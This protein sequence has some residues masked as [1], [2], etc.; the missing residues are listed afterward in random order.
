MKKII[1]CL[2]PMEDVTDT[3]FRQ[4]LCDIGRPDIFFT[5]FMNVDGYCSDG[6]EAVA[7]RISFEEM[8]RPIIVQLWGNKPDNFAKAT[9][10]IAK[11][12]KPDGI[13]INMGCSVRDV[14]KGGSCSALIKDKELSKK[15]IL[16]VKENAKGIPVSVKTRIGYDDID[17]G[18]IEFL[19]TMDLDMLTVH[20]RLAKEGYSTPSRWDIFK[21]IKELRDELSPGT[22]LIGNGDIKDDEQGIAL[23]EEYG[24]DGYMVGRSVLTNPWFF[25]GREDIS[26]KERLDTLKKHLEIF[27]RVY[28]G[29]KSFN[30]Q[31]KYI[32]AYIGGFDGA[33]K[34]REDLM[35]AS[36]TEEIK[37][38]IEK[39]GN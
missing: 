35:K 16:A 25:A 1:K 32:K 18:W 17:Y 26:Q 4:V 37:I 10:D 21:K 22:L 33:S 14:V 2:A 3:V 13:D 38:I 39:N 8:E 12:V 27:E 30:T 23:V 29:G 9:K 15:I 20:G 19:L 6:K 28:G 5:E 36:T 24:L 7:Q 34:L 11:N 31:K